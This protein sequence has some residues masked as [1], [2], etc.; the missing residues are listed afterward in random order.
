MI[1]FLL[2]WGAGRIKSKNN[3]CTIVLPIRTIW[4]NVDTFCTP[5]FG[6]RQVVKNPENIVEQMSCHF[7][8]FRTT[9]IFIILSKLFFFLFSLS[10]C[11]STVLLL[12]F[13]PKLN[14]K[15]AFNTTT[16]H[17]AIA[18]HP[19]VSMKRL[20]ISLGGLRLTAPN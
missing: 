14:N 2:L 1:L 15:V 8:Q 3:C 19:F 12:S 4:N 20:N 11:R 18:R 13:G 17:G 16:S 10:L 6:E 9:L 5:F 7:G